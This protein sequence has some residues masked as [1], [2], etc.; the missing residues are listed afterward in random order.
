MEKGGEITAHYVDSF[1]YTELPEFFYQREKAIEKEK[2][3]QESSLHEPRKGDTEKQYQ[4]VEVFGVPA[5]F[6]NGRIPEKEVPPELY[7]YDLRGLIMTLAIRLL[8][9]IMWELIMPAQSC[10]RFI[11]LSRKEDI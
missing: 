10:P 3:P 5:L 1:G 6:S 8:W 2:E 4:E 7:R 9:N 11:C